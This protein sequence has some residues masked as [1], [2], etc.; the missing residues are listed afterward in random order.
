M[1]AEISLAELKRAAIRS[2]DVQTTRTQLIPGALLCWLRCEAPIRLGCC[3][4][5]SS[6]AN[7]IKKWEESERL[8]EREKAE[9]GLQ[10][11]TPPVGHMN[12]FLCEQRTRGETGSVGGRIEAGWPKIMFF[13]SAW[14]SI[15]HIHQGYVNCLLL[16]WINFLFLR[17]SVCT[18]FSKSVLYL[19]WKSLCQER[20]KVELEP[21]RNHLCQ[22]SSWKQT[23]A[24]E[25]VKVIHLNS[26]KTCIFK[27]LLSAVVHTGNNA[28]PHLFD[29]TLQ[30]LIHMPSI[31]TD[32]NARWLNSHLV[33]SVLRFWVDTLRP[34]DSISLTELPTR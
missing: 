8:T 20:W 16:R 13:E 15:V 24:P 18:G 25:S 3:D 34:V 17:G 21:E 2:H 26:S 7:W 1:L 33:Q 11:A 6:P 22:F 19:L 12:V 29:M 23:R 31:T 28:L 10:S 9:Y 32:W 5:P 4:V 14:H 30:S 27:L